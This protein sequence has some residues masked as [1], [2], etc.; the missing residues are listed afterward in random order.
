[1]AAALHDE[2][3]HRVQSR[4]DRVQRGSNTYIYIRIIC[5]P[6]RLDSH[7]SSNVLG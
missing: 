3:V 6:L 7:V 5:S 4:F 2:S 1:M